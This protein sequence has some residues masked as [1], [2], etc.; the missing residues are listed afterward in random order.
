MIERIIVKYREDGLRGVA[1]AAGKR[2]FFWDR[3]RIHPVRAALEEV[4]KGDSFVIVQ[5]GAFVGDTG[6]DPLFGLVAERLKAGAGRLVLVEP[7][8]EYFDRLVEN[9]RGIPNV[10]FENVAIS[11][12]RGPARF[13]RLGVDPED[14]GYPSWLS[15]L[16]SLKEDRMGSLWDRYEGDPELKR[17]YLDHR[18]E[19][20][21]DCIAFSDLLAR[22][23]I[24]EVGLLQI[25]VEGYELEILKTIDFGRTSIRFV[26]YEAVLLH[27]NRIAAERLM[28]EAGFLVVYFGQ[29]AFAY[30]PADR[31]LRKLWRRSPQP[32]P[33]ASWIS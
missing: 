12:R 7:V 11:D 15:Q 22:N 5:I 21:V 6:N 33:G 3:P 10:V 23:R 30:Q 8:K 17:F 28:R 1:S 20:T 31:H 14:H 18:I 4:T 9:Y 25:D 16:G 2:I 29:D 27:E 13:Y 24:S 32:S 26:N 19:E